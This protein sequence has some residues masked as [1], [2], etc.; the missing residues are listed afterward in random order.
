M[1]PRG[2]QDG[3]EIEKEHRSNK[4]GATLRI[5]YTIL[6]ENVSNMEPVGSP[7]QSKIDKKSKQ[8]SILRSI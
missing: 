3:Q 1:P 4:E 7:N 6:E 8:K 5:T 2:G